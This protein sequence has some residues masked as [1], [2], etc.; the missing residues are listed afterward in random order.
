[1]S[2][3]K[4]DFSNPW[5]LLLL[6]PAL[7]LTLIPYFRM[8]KRYRRTRN[9]IVSIVL[10]L[11]V[12][13]LTV[14][15]LSGLSLEYDVPNKENEVILLIDTSDSS[16][17]EAKQQRDDFVKSVIDYCDSSF[18]LGIVTFGF[19]Q[20]Y[21]AEL[22]D[23]T[24]ELYSL[25]LQAPNP[26]NSATDISAALTYA[27]TLF[28]SPK[29]ARIVLISDGVETDGSAS[30]V[31]KSIA[32][33]GIKVDTVQ[34]SDTKSTS[35][36]R[37]VSTKNPDEKIKVGE[38]FLVELT[39]QSSFEGDALLT[40][41]D[42]GVAGTP[43]TVPLT[44]G[45]QTITV[46]Y[47]FTLPGMHKMSFELTS[48]DD[49]ELQNNQIN[50]YIYLE[51]FDKLL[52][53]ESIENE[54]DSLCNTLRQELNVD[55]IN[56]FDTEKM[57]TTVDE[58]RA[59]DEI[60][61]CNI[62]NADMPLGFDEILYTY[63]SEYGGGLFTICGNKADSNP[64]D[65]FFTANA[66][67][68]DDMY[69]TLYQ[70]L[71]PVEI[72]EYTPPTA[73]MI[74]IDRSGS[75]ASVSG[76]VKEDETKLAYAKL[77]AEAC[78]DA[79]TERDYV[80]IMTLSDTTTLE[81]ELT[82]RPQRDKILNAISGIHG[83]G[84]GTIYST[85]LERAGKEL[86]ALSGVERKHIIIVTDGEPSKDDTDRYAEKL[87]EN[88]ALGITISVV[89]IKC[90]SDAVARMQNML[91]E[92]AHMQEKNFHD[93]EDVKAVPEAMRTDLEAPEIKNV[94]YET[95]T[96]TV[97]GDGKITAGML[98]SEIPT[99]D[100]F[101]GVKAK[102]DAEVLLMGTY[103]PIYTQ[104]MVGKGRVGTFACDLNGT[105]S[106]DF[107]MSPNGSVIINNIIQELFPTENIQPVDMELEARGDNYLTDLSVFTQL[108][109]GEYIEF[110]VTSPAGAGELES[111]VQ[112]FRAGYGENYSKL[113]FAVKTSGI[114]EIRAVK[115]SSEGKVI[116]EAVIYKA[117]SYSKEYQ[118]F[119]DVDAATELCE[120]LA[121]SGGGSVLDDP[122]QVFANSAKFIHRIIDPRNV[123]MIL[124]ISL[125]LLGLAARKFKWKWP[126][127]IIRDRKA[128]KAISK[129]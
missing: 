3:F 51:T 85:A 120:D 119:D 54:A 65:E 76:N 31:I 41:Y 69:G 16:D 111:K 42:N 80:G 44:K 59:Y 53:I 47:L 40:P 82:P 14:A 94:N 39:L 1:M 107:V 55:V 24:E 9:R 112:S 77:G 74:I 106:G 89:G 28:N 114:H 115:K 96:P 36:V 79:L 27:S 26:D 128:T 43:I 108:G 123:C 22:T 113:S 23:E 50:S 56:V 117:L 6:I 102:K 78:L 37:L 48:N 12:M 57:P 72:I 19:D 64:N 98:D 118:V 122:Y 99:L 2:N 5:F 8:K 92:Y 100:G 21:A 11:T 52:V 73:V 103:T 87:E 4:I 20:V 86:A 68:E 63:V 38:K 129:N 88:A 13:V 84:G 35:E 127:E 93:V 121:T 83:D 49:T 116:S 10:H 25:Y 18:K 124:A 46:P 32:A 45:L 30:S 75:M 101:Y 58:L 29:S 125:F 17:A 110:T 15:V 97:K 104:W 81:L 70:Q 62:A 60:V 126:G 67:T 33:Q 66:Y 105:W 71:L 109:E 34:F 61:L 95:F 91:V 90:S 7:I